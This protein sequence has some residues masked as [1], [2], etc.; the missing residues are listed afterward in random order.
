M[1]ERVERTLNWL[2]VPV[3]IG[4]DDD[5]YYAPLRSRQLP[6]AAELYLGQVH[7]ADGLDGTRRRIA[8]AERFVPEFGIAAECGFARAR[9]PNVVKQFL[10]THAGAAAL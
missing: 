10:E 7:A 8:V 3:P 1:V 2:H 6:D 4:R 9:R 5:A